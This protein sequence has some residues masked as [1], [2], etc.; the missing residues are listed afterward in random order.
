[1]RF[2]VDRRV[3]SR[4]IG[5]IEEFKRQVFALNHPTFSPVKSYSSKIGVSR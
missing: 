4:A 5:V 2:P 1:M 3:V